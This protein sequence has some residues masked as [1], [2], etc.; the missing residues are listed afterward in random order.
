MFLK[1]IKING[2]EKIFIVDDDMMCYLLNQDA[3]KKT[4][5]NGYYE[6]L[7]A[8]PLINLME[9]ER[10]DKPNKILNKEEII[11]DIENFLRNRRGTHD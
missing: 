11:K 1:K 7:F 4:I 8:I 3:L 2:K 6:F 5:D 9:L 10:S